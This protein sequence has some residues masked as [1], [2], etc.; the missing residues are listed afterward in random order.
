LRR[1]VRRRIERGVVDE[2]LGN[3]EI[4]FHLALRLLERRAIRDVDLVPPTPSRGAP[5]PVADPAT[6]KPPSAS[7]AAYTAPSWPRPPVTIATRPET[8]KSG[9]VT[10]ERAGSRFGDA[11][12]GYRLAHALDVLER[13]VLLV[14]ERPE[15]TTAEQ[16]VELV[17]WEAPV[18]W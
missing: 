4:R 11:A 15:E 5:R 1:R 8:S 7:P 16:A 3:A 9:S 12:R 18:C 10:R 14:G 6:P 17:R 13:D 2:Q